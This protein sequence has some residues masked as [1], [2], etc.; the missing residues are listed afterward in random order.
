M[1]EERD[2]EG[3]APP[4]EFSGGESSGEQNGDDSG[5]E[6]SGD[7]ERS[8]P[9]YEFS[10]GESSG[11]ESG[12]SD[13]DD[14]QESD[15]NEL[16]AEERMADTEEGP[17][18]DPPGERTAPPYEFSGAESK[19]ED[20][21]PHEGGVRRGAPEYDFGTGESSGDQEK[22]KEEPKAP[23]TAATKI[24]DGHYKAQHRAER[25]QAKEQRQAREAEADQRERRKS[26]LKKVGWAVGA[27]LLI[28]L[29]A[30]FISTRGQ[31]ATKKGGEQAGPVVGT[32]AVAK[33]FDGIPQ[34][35]LSLGKPDAPVTLVEFADLQCPFCKQAADNA[36]PTIVDKYVRPGK[37][38]IEF[39]NFPILGP[40]S[41]TA[42]RALSGAAREGKAWQFLD[43]WYLNQG[44]ENTGY[45]TDAFIERIA[46][47]AGANPQAVL[48]A[49]HDQGN[50]AD[51]DKARAD[52]EKYGVDSTPSFLI[53]K[54]GGQFQQLLLQDPSNPDLISQS[55]DRQLGQQ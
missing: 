33:R 37:V 42:A 30:I 27:A 32:E 50:T 55:I 21:A 1:A 52:A 25:E 20:D 43:V 10:G 31:E 3:G 40:D 39:R 26:R 11:E 13:D 2:E 36:L 44:E 49:A 6:E 7:D 12:A 17:K 38:R 4:Y 54:T 51:I 14:G 8:A 22:D 53:G 46:R 28:A 34:D 35:G 23:V 9:A 15:D 41:E 24:P 45:V 18:G 29:I 48:A 47:G 5:N 19:G 16:P